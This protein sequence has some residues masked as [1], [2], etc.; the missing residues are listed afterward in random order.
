[1]NLRWV[2]F[3]IALAGIALAGA[4]LLL[5]RRAGAQTRAGPN[6]SLMYEKSC[7]Q[8]MW[9]SGTS[10]LDQATVK[11]I[12]PQCVDK[13]GQIWTL[14]TTASVYF[15]PIMMGPVQSVFGRMGEV[16]AQSGDYLFS[17]I[18]DRIDLA[19]Q[20]SGNLPVANLNGGTGAS[21]ATFWRGD[22]T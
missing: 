3:S 15:R 11:L 21:R 2:V 14:D 7:P 6:P 4:W 17:Q 22:G 1:M 8:G 9:P 20:A 10:T 13:A 5:L 19:T 18:S 16:T 12:M